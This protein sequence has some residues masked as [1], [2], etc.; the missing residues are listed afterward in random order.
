MTNDE[1]WLRRYW[2]SETPA[3]GLLDL[4]VMEELKRKNEQGCWFWH[5][6]YLA[7][8]YRSLA[9]HKWNERDHH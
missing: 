9:F 7:L 8:L 5:D 6:D 3:G 2:P 1:E 4:K